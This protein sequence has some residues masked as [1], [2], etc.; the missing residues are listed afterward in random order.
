MRSSSMCHSFWKLADLVKHT[1]GA[2]AIQC[3]VRLPLMGS[4]D[5]GFSRDQL[6][7]CGVSQE[8]SARVLLV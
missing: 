3:L 5:N 8:D 1:V 6:S 2:L 4:L 7:K